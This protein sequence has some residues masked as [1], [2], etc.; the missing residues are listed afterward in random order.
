VVTDND[1][2]WVGARRTTFGRAR[3]R[4]EADVDALTTDVGRSFA[5]VTVARMVGRVSCVC[6]LSVSS[7]EEFG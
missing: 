1:A 2:M 4:S 6:C 5:A 3:R 7:C